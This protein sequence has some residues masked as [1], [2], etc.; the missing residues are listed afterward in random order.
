M[1]SPTGKVRLKLQEEPLLCWKLGHSK[2]RRDCA[3]PRRSW[4]RAIQTGD[5]L[6]EASGCQGGTYRQ[7]ESP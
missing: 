6:T 1:V 3:A 4:P 7:V 5:S 2:T